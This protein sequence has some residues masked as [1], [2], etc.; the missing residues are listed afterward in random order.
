[1]E[2]AENFIARKKASAETASVSVKDIGRKGRHYFVRESW[3][4]MPQVNNP[5][6]VFV[7]ERF[8]KSRF[9]GTLA[10]TESWKK[11]EIEYRIGYFIVGKIGRTAGKWVW[12]Q[13]CPLIPEADLARLMDL[14]RHEGTLQG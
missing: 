4:F 8:R 6:K 9:E 5:E 10:N 12:G 3:T 7:F 1:M 11:G 14:A 13:Y 2:T